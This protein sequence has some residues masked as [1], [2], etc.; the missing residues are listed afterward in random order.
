MIRK[1]P[2]LKHFEQA[3]SSR[4]WLLNDLIAQQLKK[5]AGGVNNTQVTKTVK[6]NGKKQ[7]TKATGKET[8]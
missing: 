2:R 1:F 5:M 3:P 6:E 7:V 8:T 4:N